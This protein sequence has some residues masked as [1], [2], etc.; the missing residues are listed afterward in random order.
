MQ[1]MS[2]NLSEGRQKNDEDWGVAW[3]VA[4]R[5]LSFEEYKRMKQRKMINIEGGVLEKIDIGKKK[6]WLDIDVMVGRWW[7]LKKIEEWSKKNDK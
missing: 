2:C 3:G 7:S 5:A 6:F 4:V 1:K